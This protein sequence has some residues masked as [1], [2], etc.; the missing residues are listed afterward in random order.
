MPEF[1]RLDT[2]VDRFFKATQLRNRIRGNRHDPDTINHDV[3]TYA[4]RPWADFFV[5]Q[6]STEA[7]LMDLCPDW[8]FLGAVPVA[9]GRF[10]YATVGNIRTGESRETK[11]ISDPPCTSLLT[12]VFE[13][14]IWIL[15]QLIERVKS[16][17]ETVDE[18]LDVWFRRGESPITH[19]HLI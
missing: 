4:G 3:A 13:T 16:G 6:S 19:E 9:D 11:R 15:S 12:L 10:W 14:H 1:S 2:L 7:L 5:D 8:I 18:D 17:D